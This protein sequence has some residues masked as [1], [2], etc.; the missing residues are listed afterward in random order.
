MCLTRPRGQH[1]TLLNT[2]SSVLRL[3]VLTPCYVSIWL[4]P[5]FSAAAIHRCWLPTL[6]LSLPVYTMLKSPASK[7][8]ASETFHRKKCYLS[9]KLIGPVCWWIAMCD[10]CVFW[11]R[12]IFNDLLSCDSSMTGIC[13]V[14]QS[15]KLLPGITAVNVGLICWRAC[16]SRRLA[17]CNNMMGS[18]NCVGGRQSVS[19][20]V[21]YGTLLFPHC[22][23]NVMSSKAHT[24]L[25]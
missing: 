3:C 15:R 25:F 5:G 19:T 9:L 21:T 18:H 4:A 6:S 11:N 13:G 23:N 24:W 2:L 12:T 22:H 14:S 8:T 20:W 7:D 1:W 17:G 10:V 16:R